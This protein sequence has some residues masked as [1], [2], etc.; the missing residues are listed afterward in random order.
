MPFRFNPLRYQ[1][2]QPRINWLPLLGWV[3]LLSTALLGFVYSTT[4]AVPS[5]QLRHPAAVLVQD[6]TLRSVAADE[7]H[8]S[9][10]EV[11][12]LGD[13]VDVQSI[14]SDGWCLVTL[15]Q[16]PLSNGR[17]GTGYIQ[18][19]FLALPDSVVAVP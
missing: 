7:M 14:Q 18:R 11:L 4:R 6:A 12:Q 17:G 5:R 3:L 13:T 9:T 10:V 2:G 16:T 1:D 8:S 19:R 15:P